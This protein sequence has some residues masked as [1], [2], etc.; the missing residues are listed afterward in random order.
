MRAVTLV[1]DGVEVLDQPDPEPDAGELLVRVRAAGVNNADLLQQR[2]EY[3]PPPGAPETPGLELAGEVIAIGPGVR[4]FRPAD[5]VMAVVAGGGQADLAVVHER[6]AMPVPSGW[7]W[8]TA[9]GFPEAFTTAHDA[10]FTQCGLTLGERVCVHGGAG[11]VGTAAVQLAAAAG[12]NVLATVRDPSRR[13]AVA[14]L[15]AA[16]VVDPT[17]FVVHGPFD[18]VVELVGAPNVP[19]DLVALAPGGRISVLGVEA[20]EAAELDLGALMS[21]RGR[22]FGSTLRSRSLEEKAAAARLV[23]RHVLRLAPRLH[24]PVHARFPLSDA[25]AAYEC[26]RAGGKLGKIV[27]V[28]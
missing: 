27:L 26:F 24:V 12:A 14:N 17:D 19:H 20:G 28:C 11:G 1:G 21:R 10:L 2:G 9:G 7:D 3:P 23:E 15:G 16:E 22:I 13:P 8:P 4:R 25:A 18:V 5:R 6:L